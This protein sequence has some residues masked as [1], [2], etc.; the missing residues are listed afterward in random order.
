MK[1]K[2]EYRVNPLSNDPGGVE[3]K[4]YYPNGEVRIYDKV[5]NPGA[6][7][8]KVIRNAK[9]LPEQTRPN[10][11]TTLEEKVLWEI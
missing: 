4:V 2:D 3:V 9:S 6:F 10:K 8:R 11:I 7:A 1:V 5:K